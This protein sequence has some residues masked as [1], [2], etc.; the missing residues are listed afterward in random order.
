MELKILLLQRFH[1]FQTAASKMMHQTCGVRAL[2]GVGG[3]IGLRV[4]LG[5][6]LLFIKSIGVPNGCHSGAAKEEM[7]HIFVD[8]AEVAARGSC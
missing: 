8:G 4:V 1:M 2:P 3:P 5:G 6:N 7:F